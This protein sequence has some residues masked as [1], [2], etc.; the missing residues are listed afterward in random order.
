MFR[1]SES[2]STYP[3]ATDPADYRKRQRP[4]NQGGET[5]AMTTETTVNEAFAAARREG[6]SYHWAHRHV[7]GTSG[8]VATCWGDGGFEIDGDGTLRDNRGNTVAKS[9]VEALDESNQQHVDCVLE[10]YGA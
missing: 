4:A 6:L 10:W 9:S 2:Q 5:R 3:T 8:F 1:E 7:G